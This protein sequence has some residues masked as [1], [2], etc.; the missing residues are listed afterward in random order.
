MIVSI[1]V[2]GCVIRLLNN[3]ITSLQNSGVSKQRSQKF[4][5]TF[6]SLTMKNSQFFS[7]H[8]ERD[9]A[10]KI[11]CLHDTERTGIEARTGISYSWW[12]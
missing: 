12:S 11:E 9:W 3:K 6:P 7:N 4:S 8:K 1:T 2:K 5:I 10:G